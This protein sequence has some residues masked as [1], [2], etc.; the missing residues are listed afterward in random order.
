MENAMDSDTQK[1]SALLLVD[2]IN[3]IVADNGK[4]AGKGYASYV[5]QFGTLEKVQALLGRA[6]AASMP[7]I[8]VGLAFREGYQDH[9]AESPLFGSAKRFGALLAGTEATSFHTAA[10]PVAGEVT[11]T[12]SR[13]SAF[14]GTTL[15][16][17]LRLQGVTNIYVSGVATDLAVQ[18]AVRDAHDRDFAVTV[19][20]D[21]CAAASEED[22]STSLKT[23]AK[24]S[25]MLTL[26][27][28][29]F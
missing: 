2:W 3:E 29:A 16:S 9:P 28:V 15:E 12:K 4:L 26:G 13:V 8:H 23:L 20:H 27:D 17:I 19:I 25:K 7:V 24:I 18:S 6:R 10:A 11:L 14:F 22:H 5:R 21:C 1:K